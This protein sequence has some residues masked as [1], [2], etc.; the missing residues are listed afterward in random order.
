MEQFSVFEPQCTEGLDFA[1]N[2][3]RLGSL[4]LHRCSGRADL[5]DFDG[6]FSV[7]AQYRSLLKARHNFKT[8]EGKPAPTSSPKQR[9]LQELSESSRG[10]T[11]PELAVV[12]LPHSEA[13]TA[14]GGSLVVPRSGKPMEML[15]NSVKLCIRPN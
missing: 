7:H 10:A 3:V 12:T 4:H 9:F 14:I 2:G 8:H 5:P 1:E 6:A 13:P 11:Q 15:P